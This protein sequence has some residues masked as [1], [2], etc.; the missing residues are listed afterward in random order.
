MSLKIVGDYDAIIT[1]VTIK[2]QFKSKVTSQMS[3]ELGVDP[4]NIINVE[5][6]KGSILVEFDLVPSSNS[7]APSLNES[8]SKLETLV[9][10]GGFVVTFN[11]QNLTANTTSFTKQEVL[12][13]AAPTT[14]APET[15]PKGKNDRF[16]N[17][18]LFYKKLHSDRQK[19]KKLYW[20]S[21]FLRNS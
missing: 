3:I 14:T 8:M 16:F 1:N 19:V 12:A 6:S 13:T 10:S 2:S 21:D 11:G 5:I 9:K 17:K 7:S 4:A 20:D 15:T 18:K